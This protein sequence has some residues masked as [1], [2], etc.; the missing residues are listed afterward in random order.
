MIL[1]CPNCSASLII[2]GRSLNC[3]SGHSFDISKA[4]YTN[5]LLP[6]QKKT[7]DPGDNKEM[8]K[9][10]EAFL[11]KGHYKF[12]VDQLNK[13]LSTQ[14][15]SNGS[16]LNIVD[17][18]CGSGYYTRALL[19]NNDRVVKTGLDISKSSIEIASKKDKHSA[20]IVASA[21]NIP[22]QN[23]SCDTILNIFAPLNLDQIYNIINDAGR[24]YKVIP[25]SNHMHE[26]AELVY[27]TFKPHHDNFKTEVFEDGRFKIENEI[28]LNQELKLNVE[29]IKELISM[30]PYRYKFTEEQF[31]KLEGMKVSISFQILVLSKK[32]I[33]PESNH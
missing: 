19:T 16:K 28:E 10:R 13:L 25:G 12:L 18:G 22:I 3:T 24:I 33:T 15:R 20:Y 14:L 23:K 30:T 8:I 5:L 21:F 26:I 1:T 31:E 17:I 9:A 11:S 32:I 4:G 6:N 27:D 29:E 2:N 7:L